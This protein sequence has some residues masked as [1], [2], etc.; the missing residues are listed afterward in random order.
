MKIVSEKK[1]MSQDNTEKSIRILTF[2]GKKEDWMMWLD[3]FIAKAMMKGYNE[4][5]DGTVLVPDDNVVTPTPSEEEA[6]KLNKLA[7]NEL[8]LACTDKIA[9]GIVKN[10][11]TKDHKKGNSKIAWDRLKTKYEPNTGTELL[12]INKEY[13]SMELDDIKKDPEDFITDLDK[14]R[15]RMADDTF[16]EIITDKSFMLHVLNSLP[17]EYESIVETMER[18]LGA[19]V[20]TIDDLKEQVR[21]KYQRLVKKTKLKDDKLAL[22]ANNN[23]YK[24]K[25]GFKG[26]CRICGKYGHKAADY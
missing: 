2:S 5:L 6:I 13:M 25:Q 16:N 14:L 12:A 21:S 10:A 22:L 15:T 23:K 3:K 1:N 17:V 19:G 24:K 20:L 11:K 18:D 9:F 7:Y 4:I 8:I 26:N